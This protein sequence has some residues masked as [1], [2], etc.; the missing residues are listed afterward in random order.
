MRSYRGEVVMQEKVK[1]SEA[2]EQTASAL[3]MFDSDAL[4]ELTARLNAA[5]EGLVEIERE[6]I[7]A[8]KARQRILAEVLIATE[9]SIH[10]LRSLR[11]RKARN[12]WAL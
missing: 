11:E 10:I 9:R 12:E 1:L 2:L 4:E 6:P 7:E 8:I 3:A 5:T